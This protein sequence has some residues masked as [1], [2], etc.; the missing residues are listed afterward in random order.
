MLD[1]WLVVCTCP[2]LPSESKAVDPL[3]SKLHSLA[4]CFGVSGVWKWLTGVGGGRGASVGADGCEIGS[5]GV[6]NGLVGCDC[7]RTATGA[8]VASFSLGVYDGVDK[9]GGGATSGSTCGGVVVSIR[10]ATRCVWERCS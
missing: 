9:N 4:D 6:N 2:L 1:W 8:G 10:D 7:A 5:L 3:D